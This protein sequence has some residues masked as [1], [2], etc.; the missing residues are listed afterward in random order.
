[1]ERFNSEAFNGKRKKPWDRI[2][3]LSEL[4]EI[5][6]NDERV[7]KN[8][9]L[10]ELISPV[11][12]QFVPYPKKLHPSVY[13]AFASRGIERLFS[14]QA[15]AYDL[16]A[17]GKDLVVATPT[18]SGKSLCYK[19]PVLDALA[20]DKG[21]TAIFLF[22]T[23]ALSRDQETALRTDLQAAGLSRGAVTYDGDTPQD[24]RRAAR[25]KSSV[26]IT[27]PDML[28][29]GILP[30]H[31][32]WARMFAGLRYVVI[33][34]IH[35]YRG[36][37][38]S[39]LANVVRRLKRIARFHGSNPVFIFASATI[40]NPAAHASSMVGRE[41]SLIDQTGAPSGTRQLMVFN[42]PVVNF[43]LGIR[44]SYIKAA[45][46]FGCDLVRAGVTTLIF[47]Q[48][49][50]NVEVMLKYIRDRL[51]RDKI[52]PETIHGYRGGYLPKVRRQIES[53]LRDGSIRCVVAT[54]ALELGIDIGS[55]DAVVC[56][57]Y[58]GTVAG[59]WQRFGRGGRRGGKALSLLVTSSAPLDQYIARDDLHLTGAP[60]EQARIDPD[61]I[62]ILMQHLKCASFE[63]PFEEGED[64]GHLP[65]DLVKEALE[66]LVS[67]D[68]L[69]PARGMGGKTVYHWASNAYP[70]GD[71]SL[72]SVGEDN[73]VIIDVEGDIAIGEM[74]FHAAHT[75]LHEQAI[76][77]QGG[78]QY[79]VERLDFDNRKSY[80]R[81][82]TPDYFTN[83]MTH[84]SVTVIE[85][86]NNDAIDRDSKGLLI[87]CSGDVRVVEKVVGYKKI[88]YHTHEN[89]GYGDV[90]LPEMNM[91]T[92]AFWLTVPEEIV[93]VQA[94]PRPIVV[95][96][97]KG[98]AHGMHIVA[99]VGLMI[100]PRDLGY[101]LGDRDDPDAPPS[102]GANTGPGFDPTIFLYDH[103]AGGIG[104]APRLFEER[105]ALL[106]RTRSLLENCECEAGCPVC[107]GPL[108]DNL[109]DDL[110][111]YSRKRIALEILSSV[112]IAAI[113]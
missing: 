57:G 60:V 49:R 54:N 74:D 82:V 12:A 83:A 103:V 26:L 97:L 45:V 107:I 99:S 17:A 110:K 86:D 113:H 84:V 18:A 75:M 92:T 65:A 80:V 94:A 33:D 32:N 37:F 10:N 67:S 11:E 16:A 30:H 58:P 70:A 1:M 47:G 14:H 106:R 15:E 71:I 104:L 27:N 21:S 46:R 39:H 95:D 98:L 69:Q 24:A 100:D 56:A 102:K 53:Q 111:N 48:S 93:K 101:C 51:M 5:W 2:R 64:F 19:L 31:A 52:D 4:L 43:E 55:I 7:F 112:G 42:P 23:K 91:E 3:G 8:I 66:H 76:Y 38:G 20:K 72:R 85:E 25:E 40:G 41:V 61:N 6:H 35:S 68:I 44:Q 28:H 81:K 87:A 88:K 89:L 62:E 22:P 9:V 34:E 79:Q 63:L 13:K 105:H 108:A 29:A 73:F 59:L 78:E 36:V 50:N 109:S 96:A 90:D 77:Q